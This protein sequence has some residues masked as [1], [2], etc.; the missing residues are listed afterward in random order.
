M[1]S[2]IPS[3]EILNGCKVLLVDDS[4][5]VYRAM[6]RIFSRVGIETVFA[7]Q[8]GEAL[9]SAIEHKVDAIVLD[10]NLGD[11][12]GLDV[13]RDLRSHELTKDIPIII[14]TANSDPENHIAALDA[15]G[16]DFVPK[17][18]AQKVLLRRLANVITQRRATN[19]NIRLL[20]EIE[21][22]IS[23][24]AVNQVQEQKGIE[25]IDAT[26][27]FSDMR[28]FTAASFGHDISDVFNAINLA[29]QFQS[30]IIEDFGGYVDGFSGDGMLAVFD[31]DNG[32]QAACEAAT[33]IIKT[34]RVTKVE[35]WD[36]MP[37]GIGINFGAVMRGDLGSSTRR[38]HTVIGSTVN[39]SARLCGVARVG[40]AVASEEV[41][42]KVK[43]Y[44]EFSDPQLVRLKGLP[45]PV[46][47]YSLIIP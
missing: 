26:I 38:T 47:A 21:T 31:Q 13:C 7:Q 22:Y 11:T 18:P 32:P 24:A 16:D 15:G 43:D 10:I 27:L 9:P 28:G 19:E 40:E 8:G 34:S 20:K 29:M 46:F 30:K 39:V 42:D 6:Q 25:R 36:P 33:E 1:K 44:F 37:I 4:Y 23:S 17:P 14:I 5:L 3:N 45:Q 12:D 41:K 2:T 35:I